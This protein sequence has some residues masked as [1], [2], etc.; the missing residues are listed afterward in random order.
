M[1]FIIVFITIIVIMMIIIIIIFIISGGRKPLFK[2]YYVIFPTRGLFRIRDC[3][4][5]RSVLLGDIAFCFQ[6]TNAFAWDYH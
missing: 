3:I 2:K 4:S 1:M 5:D 6:I